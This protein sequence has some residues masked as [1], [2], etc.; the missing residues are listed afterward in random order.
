[1][2]RRRTRIPLD[3]FLNARLVG[4]LRRQTSGAIEFQYDT[5]W[6]GWEHTLPLSLSLPLREDRYIG[7]PVIAVF[8]NLLPDAELIRRRVAERVRADG[9]DAYSLLAKVGRDC[10]GALQFLPEG[11]ESGPAG[12]ID[13]RIVR[14]AEIA[15]KIGD[16][17]AT[18]LGVDE[19]EEFR[20]SLAGAQEKTALLRLRG[21]WRVPRGT[22]PTTHILK[23]QIGRLPAGI[24]LTQSVENEY[25]CMKLTAAFGLPTAAVEI[26]DFGD[27]RVLVVERFDRRWTVDKRLLRL[28]QEDCCQALSVPPTRKYE[29]EG[30]P[31]IANVLD[32]L[33]ASDDPESDQRFFLAAQLMFWL[34]GATDGHAK[35]FSIFL[36]PGGRFRLTPLYDVMSAQPARDAGQLQKNKT[37][38]ALAVGDR[39]HYV[40]DSILP[41]HFIQTAQRNGVPERVIEEICADFLDRADTAIEQT[42]AALPK[43]FP[44]ALVEPITG[45]LRARL[46]LIEHTAQ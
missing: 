38:L 30:G 25:L 2:A 32:L 39:R 1:M 24:D 21:K 4:Q 22:T 46:R 17:A 42:L 12:E 7:D 23:P 3:V 18:P 43:D 14:D 45:G 16:L 35:N 8:D 27:H 19:D 9:Y 29:A 34:L 36:Q 33:K 31:G 44:V 37:K 26:T 10:V 28:P 15:A 5:D 40:I 41:R 13:S 20:I 11:Q 6:L